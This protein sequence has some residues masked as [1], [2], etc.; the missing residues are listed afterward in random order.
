MTI[1]VVK[2][3][4]SLWSISRSF[5]ISMDSIVNVNKLDEISRLVIGQALVIP[6]VERVYT[7]RAGD[8][9]WLIGRRFG[10][11]AQR[12][13]QY[14]NLQYPYLLNIG[15]T[16]RIPENSKNY[17]YIEVNGYIEPS[18][19]ARE[20]SIVNETAKYQTF[21]TPFSYEVKEDGTLKNINVDTILETSSKYQVAS[22]MAIT[23]FKE[24]NFNSEL[25]HTVLSNNTIRQ[26]LITNIISTMKS[27]K[28]YGLN[29][30]FERLFP[31]DKE[32][33]NNFL[34][35]LAD[36]LHKNN[37][38]LSTALAP[39]I[40]EEQVGEWYEAHDY[41]A[42]GEIA[43]FV[44]IMTYE[45]GWS[46]GPPLPVAPI[47]SVRRVLDYAVSV[48]PRKKIMMGMPLYGYNWTLPYVPGGPFAP[49][50]S[51][52]QAI[53]IAAK[54]G[55]E[56]QYDYQEESPFFYYY[57]EN[58]KRHI[59]WFEDARSAKAKFLTAVEYGLR[60]VSYWV[61]GLSFPQNWALLNDMFNI[62]KVIK[63]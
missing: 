42:H 25:G 5:G 34:R 14:N 36:V 58:R 37:F 28:F 44:V 15:M 45:W 59:V 7:V 63:S 33:Y 27:K 13:A 61:L 52:Q 41:A 16:L 22:L 6:T 53:N 31:A 50:V 12:I 38:I 2:Q 18:T 29:V 51:P 3:G 40:S 21:I 48:I 39:K 19:A 4:D 43:D 1:Y 56:I 10:V 23:N 49:R 20:A 11:T 47:R 8:T 55:A 62:V 35:E 60:G 24:G 17:G 9:L 32:L 30:D 54:Y 57:D 46:G 26:K